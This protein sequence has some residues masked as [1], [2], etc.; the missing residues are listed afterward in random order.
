MRRSIVAVTAVALAASLGMAV[1]A[2]ADRQNA[3]TTSATDKAGRPA[4][5]AAEIDPASALAV[6]SRIKSG[7]ARPGDPSLT[8]ALRNLAMVQNKLVGKAAVDARAL[9]AR[10]GLS[11]K[12]KK[13]DSKLCLHWSSDRSN[14]NY[15]KRGWAIKSFKQM[16]KVWKFET[17]KLGYRRPPKDFGEAGNR[18]FDVYLQNI[19]VQGLYGYCQAERY[20]DGTGRHAT[21]YCVLDNNFSRAEFPTNSPLG[22]L[23]VT[24]AHEFFHAIQ[25]GYKYNQAGWLMESTATWMEER[26]ADNVND[27]R[28][29]LPWSQIKKPSQ[30]LA[31]TK[32]P[33]H[34]GNW[35]FWEYFSQRKGKGLVKKLW[36]I[37]ERKPA[38]KA[39]KAAVG[40]KK[41]GSSFAKYAGATLRPSDGW[42]EGKAYP[43]APRA[44]KSLSKGK[45]GWKVSKKLK[46]TTMSHVVLTPQKSLKKKGWKLRV[47]FK[48]WKGKKGAVAYVAAKKKGGKVVT[49]TV[50]INGHG[51]GKA[52]MPFR[53][54]KVKGVYVTMANYGNGKSHKGA[55]KVRAIR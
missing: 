46:K 31:K 50:K 45:R 2:S 23:K 7:N 17:K 24:A 15:A 16:Q 6:A 41:F 51:R 21:S 54:G 39:M 34:Y 3:T 5:G 42:S 20:A 37:A 38:Y 32:S 14:T 36:K 1:P 26:F 11:Q 49:K 44:H 30:P 19:G 9:M 52:V 47:T 22:N 25:F 33:N 4:V 29:Y 12:R 13:C 18:K 43:K 40:G 35:I 55:V 53:H 8:I 28:N 48:M 27:N 10:P